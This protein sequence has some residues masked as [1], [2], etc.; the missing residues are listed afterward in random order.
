MRSRFPWLIA[1]LL[2]GW[3]ATAGGSCDGSGSRDS[4]D[5]PAAPPEE[6]IAAVLREPDAFVRA[7]SLAELLSGLGPEA[8][9]AVAR[10][11]DRNRVTH[12]SGEFE[13]L[14]HFWAEHDPDGAARWAFAQQ[15]SRHAAMAAGT[16][17]EVMARADPDAARAALEAARDL[18]SDSAGAAQVALVRG[19]FHRDREA[20]EE[21]IADLDPSDARDRSL[22]GFALELQ[23]TD[24]S[25]AV[26]AWAES[27]PDA[28][29]S[30][31]Q[32]AHRQV[33]TA[34]AWTD[35]EGAARWC[36]AHC[37]GP[38]G[39][40]MR[41]A[42]AKTLIRR[43][44]DGASVLEWAARAPESPDNDL[45]LVAVYRFWLERDRGVALEWVTRRLDES[46]EPWMRKL[47]GVYA[48]ALS[49]TS[50]A[51]AVQWLEDIEVTSEAE[52]VARNELLIEI[53]RRWHRIA[54]RDAAAWLAQSPL[55]EPERERAR[56]EE[57]E[58]AEPPPAETGISA[59][60]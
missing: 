5:L 39:S 51:D 40:G 15:R 59:E 14:V 30:L 49:A 60:L 48:R 12:R 37:D 55:S 32:A 57:P 21:Y 58:A 29:E 13:L 27:L 52:A 3:L 22:L 36:D 7:G 38:F 8:V 16:A 10:R 23:R 54:P 9:P 56:G 31:N 28:D 2:G 34:L 45:T 26:I 44:E 53:S 11:L 6:A 33:A 41:A 19:W 24:G 43:G 42:I 1:L 20:V 18:D 50:P 4:A 35:R 25:D 47:Y 17:V 46:P